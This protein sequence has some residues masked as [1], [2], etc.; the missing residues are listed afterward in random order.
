MIVG[1]SQRENTVLNPRHH[2]RRERGFAL[3]LTLAVLSL[4]IPVATYLLLDARLCLTMAAHLRAATEA[5]YAAE[6][7]LTHALAELSADPSFDR[8][9]AAGPSRGEADLRPFPFEQPP[10]RHFPRPPLRYDVWIQTVDA[11]SVE[12]VSRGSGPGESCQVVGTIVAKDSQPELPAA[13]AS[14]VPLAA[15]EVGERVRLGVRDSDSPDREVAGLATDGPEPSSEIPRSVSDAVADGRIA[16]VGAPAV[17]E[18]DLCWLEG[19][20]DTIRGDPSL[21]VLPPNACGP[22]GTGA[23]RTLGAWDVHAASG[24]G[25]LLVDGDLRVRESL[26]FRGLL[27]VAGNIVF[28]AASTGT[29][30]GAIVQAQPGRRLDLAGAVSVVYDPEALA[31]ADRA[32]RGRLP[33]RTVVGSWRQWDED[34]SLP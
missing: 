9:T 34:A 5:F 16:G 27:L 23:F 13:L 3:L 20:V 10:D 24:A 11:D 32:A 26:S 28:D 8:L 4:L 30:D 2:R 12:I 18:S 14:V 21:S 6:S 29:I 15:V 25:L 31:A 7:G 1:A 22:L 19:L 33:R 17:R